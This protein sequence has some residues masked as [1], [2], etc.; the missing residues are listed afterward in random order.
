MLIWIVIVILI[1][2][3]FF[4]KNHVSVLEQFLVDQE[5][6]RG[7]RKHFVGKRHHR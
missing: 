4:N 5:K 6:V 2:L 3:Y 1:A 7:L